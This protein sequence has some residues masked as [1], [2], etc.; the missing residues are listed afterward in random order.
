MIHNL[1]V[2]DLK[3]ANDAQA[4]EIAALKKRIQRLE[5]RKISRPTSLKRLR[6]V[7]R[8]IGDI[9]ADVE[10]TLVDETQVRQN[11]DLIFDTGVFGLFVDNA[12]GKL[13]FDL[14]EEQTDNYKTR[15]IEGLYVQEPSEGVKSYIRDEEPSSFTR[16]KE[17]VRKTKKR[18]N[19]RYEMETAKGKQKERFAVEKKSREGTA[20]RIPSKKTKSRG[21][22]EESEK[23]KKMNKLS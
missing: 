10:V 19:G 1:V 7:G 6:K 16:L 5:R 2:L 23:L 12:C 22:K 9:D 15:R 17:K 3:K 4:K 21:K 13:R 11:D 20:E 8:S 18:R 14:K